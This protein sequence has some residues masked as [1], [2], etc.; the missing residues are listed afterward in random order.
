MSAGDWGAVALMVP[1]AGCAAMLA[2]E[3]RKVRRL[4]RER[5][6]R[7]LPGPPPADPGG[8]DLPGI[9]TLIPF[10]PRRPS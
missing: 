1:A 2:H 5:P 4:W 6:P 7:D 8:P 10:V 3:L 9:G